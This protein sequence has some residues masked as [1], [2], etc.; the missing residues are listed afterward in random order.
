ME[1]LTKDQIQEISRIGFYK[2]EIDPSLDLF[3][4]IEKMKKEKMKRKN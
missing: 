2:T 1:T 4:E 3:S